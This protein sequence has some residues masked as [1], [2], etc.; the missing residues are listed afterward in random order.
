MGVLLEGRGPYSSTL[1]YGR[2]GHDNCNDRFSPSCCIAAEELEGAV[3][4]LPA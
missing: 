4:G 1:G 2:V 3:D